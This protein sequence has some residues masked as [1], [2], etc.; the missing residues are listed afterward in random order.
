MKTTFNTDEYVRSHGR[1][2]KGTGQWAFRIMGTDGL[3]SWTT[4]ADPWFAPCSTLTAAKKAAKERG[5]S[6][7]RDIGRVREIVIDVLG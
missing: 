3:G 7:A 1:D 6:M 4:L 5:K 2:P